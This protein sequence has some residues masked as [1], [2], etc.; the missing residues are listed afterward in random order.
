MCYVALSRPRASILVRTVA[1]LLI[2]VGAFALQP[3]EAAETTGTLLGSIV[4]SGGTQ[5]IAGATITL[6]GPIESSTTSDASGHFTFL[7][8]PPGTYTL[9]VSASGYRTTESRELVINA[10]NERIEHLSLTPAPLRE[11]GHVVARSRASL[12]QPGVTNDL[13]SF[14]PALQE[15][16]AL[17]NGGGDR[18]TAYPSISTVPGVFV[19]IGPAGAT[20]QHISIRGADWTQ[21]G[22]ELDGVSIT[23]NFDHY[24]GGSLS[25]LANA[26]IQVD[27][28]SAPVDQ[29]A[30]GIG[31]YINQ[32]L[33][34]GTYPGF[35]H[36]DM[37]VG[38]PS[39]DQSLSLEVGGAD[40]PDRLLT[41]DLAVSGQ[42]A[43]DHLI[44]QSDG[45]TF[46]PTHGPISNVIAVDTVVPGCGNSGGPNAGHPSAGC[47]VN[48]GST[49]TNGLPLGPNGYVT[50]PNLWGTVPTIGTG[51]VLANIHAA[52]LHHHTNLRDDLQILGVSG[53]DRTTLNA[54][55]DDLGI[56]AND[57]TNGTVTEPSGSV[58]GTCGFDANSG[59]LIG[60]AAPG[61]T[62]VGPIQPFYPD[63]TLFTGP[64]YHPLTN[65]DLNS[66][67]TTSLPSQNGTPS[68]S[69]IPSN[70][71]DGQQASFA[72]AKVAYTHHF[73]N[74]L[75]GRLTLYDVSS[76]RTENGL[77]TAFQP[78][79]SASLEPEYLLSTHTN[80]F[81]AALTD[82]LSA[83]HLLHLDV[84]QAFTHTLRLDNLLGSAS[85]VA[86]LVNGN[87]PFAGCYGNG[88]PTLAD[89]STAGSTT[90]QTAASSYLFQGSTTLTPGPNSPT[91][92]AL[93]GL[94]CGT[95]PCSYEVIS[96]G[97]S[98][99]ISTVAPIFTNASIQDRWE[100]TPRLFVDLGLRYD[101]FSYRMADTDTPANQ[102]LDSS[103]NAFHCI[104]GTTIVTKTS[105]NEACSA[106]GS[107][108]TPTTLN[109]S[110]PNID[111]KELQ[112]R[113][114]FTYTIDPKNV[115]RLSY[116][117]YAQAPPS[118]AV[119]LTTTYP[120]TPNTTLYALT[121]TNTATQPLTAETSTNIDASWEHGFRNPAMSL[122]LTP[123][124]RTSQG[125]FAN[126]P[127]DPKSGFSAFVNGL[128]RKSTGF[129]V[130]FRS[131][132]FAKNGLSTQLSYA[133]THSTAQYATFASGGSFVSEINA[134]LQQYNG[135][136]QFCSTHPGD[137]RCPT[138]TSNAAPCYGLASQSGGALIANGQGTTSCGPGLIANPY[139][140][141]QPAA[142][143]D[144]NASYVPFNGALGPG[145]SGTSTSPTLP[146]LASIVLHYRHNRF[147]VTP[148]FV[149]EAGARYGSPFAAQGVAPDSCTGTYA[150]S[151]T[152]DPRYVNGPPTGGNGASP[153]DASTC[154]G[155]VV[156]PDPKTGMFDGIGAFRQ[157]DL[158]TFNLGL[159]YDTSPTTT[160]ELGAA[161]L[162][163]RCFGGSAVPWQTGGL[164][165]NEQ[166]AVPFV[167]NFYN[168][169]DSI[170]PIVASPYSAAAVSAIQNGTATVPLPI[171]LYLTAHIRL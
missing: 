158:L 122:K 162:L 18:Y 37:G 67:N 28:G 156:I 137:P 118:S 163:Y 13:T 138:N 134:A 149:F 77:V 65:A 144:P 79:V 39:K 83:Q 147:S 2:L 78:F 35:V 121:G 99:L 157:P 27:S 55:I 80:G 139:W 146:H 142:L 143:L 131:G 166:Q 9:S 29:Q 26:E 3:T 24:P 84:G 87:A 85:P 167:G 5:A 170:Q 71:S 161:N 25:N 94:T 49:S 133:Y 60:Y 14:L 30:E 36:L 72:L 20:E 68:Y 69:T 135:Y 91:L 15:S 141:A 7:T 51:E 70:Q 109:A 127:L 42:Q 11:I 52:F 130:L 98:A 101:D 19:P 21:V 57:I 165:C 100:V 47:Y 12:V 33:R 95:G 113:L 73:N 4:A 53:Q 75:N 38:T 124:Y 93:P 119:Q 61:C 152:G 46:A 126:L 86:V 22:Y 90:A 63:T 160:I 117:R 89:C 115:I 16:T 112:P 110:S 56:A 154:Y 45:S 153:Y 58:L 81:D 62:L 74:E 50:F 151:T 43:V 102:L 107:G 125:E 44:D 150:G 105:A 1:L 59:A 171:E 88:A 103:Y 23:R 104:A 169:G 155:A 168:P 114:G 76:S 136:T 132:N 54:S 8:L 96:D 123:Y 140:N 120:S 129:E 164:A 159:S 106:F 111:I 66:G 148:S 64:L 128:N 31:G 6:H 145:S 48:G 82:R 17:V 40:G 32:V 97:S 34:T 108:Y 10:D 92:S 41:Y 116:G